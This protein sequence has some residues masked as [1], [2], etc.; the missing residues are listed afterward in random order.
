MAKVLVIGA[1]RGIGL[2]TVSLHQLGL[3]TVGDVAHADPRFFPRS[4]DCWHHSAGL[5]RALKSCSYG[6]K[7]TARSIER[8]QSL[9]SATVSLGA[10]M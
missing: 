3:H 5:T 7:G 4:S 2:E 1:S 10:S 6:V 9:M 8:L